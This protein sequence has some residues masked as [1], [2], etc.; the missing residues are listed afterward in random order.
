MSWKTSA[1]SIPSFDVEKMKKDVCKDIDSVDFEDISLDKVSIRIGGKLFNLSKVEDQDIDVEREIREE[2][3][4]KLT[5]ILEDLKSVV[6]EKMDQSKEMVD[7]IRSDYENK[8]EELQKKINQIV[9]MPD[10]NY[11]HARKGLSVVK[12]SAE[13]ELLWLVRRVYWPKYVDRKPIKSLYIKK[14]ITPIIVLINTVGEKVTSVTTRQIGNLD[15][16][17][18]YH[19]SRPDCW[20]NWSPPRSWSTPYDIIDIANQAVVVLENINSSSLATRTPR[21]LPRFNTLLRNVDHQSQVANVD[22]PRS[23]LGRTGIDHNSD[24]EDVEDSIWTS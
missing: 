21:G 16:F 17:H 8:E 6:I 15:Y 24:N 3:R 23:S 12:G 5:K 18:H 2:Y 1:K 13:G 19:Q 20:G 4:D 22:D 9:S 10:I 7:V 14:M 11:E